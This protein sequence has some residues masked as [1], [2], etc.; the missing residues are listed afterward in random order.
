MNVYPMMGYSITVHL[1][2]EASRQRGRGPARW[3]TARRSLQ[4]TRQLSAPLFSCSIAHTRIALGSPASQV[5]EYPAACRPQPP[6]RHV[7]LDIV[8]LGGQCLQLLRSVF[9]KQ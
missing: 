5:A 2:D 7:L 9:P 8:I 4:A 1:D 3:T 6:L